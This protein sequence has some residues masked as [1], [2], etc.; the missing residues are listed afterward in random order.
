MGFDSG[1]AA[2]LDVNGNQRSRRVCREWTPR[3]ANRSSGCRRSCFHA[4]FSREDHGLGLDLSDSNLQDAAAALLLFHALLQLAT[5][6]KSVTGPPG[7][8]DA[9]APYRGAGMSF[10]LLGGLEKR[11]GGAR[12]RH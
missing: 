2:H 8:A 5:P 3:S 10:A 11:A 9:V 4:A 6:G 12:Q 7:Q 1:D